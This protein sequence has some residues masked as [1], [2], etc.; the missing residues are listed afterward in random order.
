MPG[1]VPV[2]PDADQA[3][4]WARE[5][6]AGRIYEEAKPGLAE[7]VLQSV[8]DWLGDVLNGLG[9]LGTG[10]GVLILAATAVVLI[11]VLVLVVRPRLNA[12]AKKKKT[13][14]VFGS[15]LVETANDHRARA[16]EAASEQRWDTAVAERFR[17]MVRSAEERV[18]FEV[19]PA[20]TAAEAAA[21]LSGAF[22]GSGTDIAWLGHRFDEIL[23][24]DK[25]ARASDYQRAVELDSTLMHTRPAMADSASLPGMA[26]PR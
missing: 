13:S 11:A 19:R 26:V 16:D 23:Y 18:I 10:P 22:P 4:D 8:L 21:S 17:A 1:D 15:D 14:E 3:R 5:E 6:L 7:R 24:G 25:A 12:K 2:E 20:R 9:G